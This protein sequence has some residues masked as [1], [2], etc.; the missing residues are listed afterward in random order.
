MT[1]PAL[2]NRSFTIPSDRAWPVARA[3]GMARLLMRPD[4]TSLAAGLLGGIVLGAVAAPALPGL[5]AG[6]SPVSLA[7]AG[8][9]AI[10]AAVQACRG[11]VA[12]PEN[13]DLRPAGNRFEAPEALSR[14]EWLARLSRGGGGD[15]PLSEAVVGAALS[16]QLTPAAQGMRPIHELLHAAFAVHALG[17]RLKEDKRRLDA[18]DLLR[19]VEALGA[20]DDLAAGKYLAA[21]RQR[22]GPGDWDKVQGYTRA[23]LERHAMRE[24]GLMGALQF[25]RRKR[26]ILPCAEFRWLKA[27]DRKAWYALQGLGRPTPHVEGLAAF[28]HF[29]AEHMAGEPI[30]EPQ[31]E[32]ACRG[33]MATAH[34]AEEAA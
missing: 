5:V 11:R 2:L 33:L 6:V 22:L 23:V 20:V 14:E 7:M 16:E 4:P 1:A 29:A 21:L 34:P 8:G 25:G 19:E 24:T 28:S 31:V 9:L 10:A 30:A 18:H 27:A 13:G 32:E 26:G 12:L 15:A 17:L 3:R